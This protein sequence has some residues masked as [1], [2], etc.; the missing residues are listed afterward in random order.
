VSFHRFDAPHGKGAGNESVSRLATHGL[1][2][3][4]VGKV[5]GVEVE[6]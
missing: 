3:G 4:V 5:F 2:P 1:C 6:V